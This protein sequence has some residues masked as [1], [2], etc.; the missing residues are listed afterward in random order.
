MQMVCQIRATTDTTVNFEFTDLV[1][2]VDGL[3]PTV[4]PGNDGTP[5]F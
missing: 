1:G 5:D 4:D 3:S 2:D